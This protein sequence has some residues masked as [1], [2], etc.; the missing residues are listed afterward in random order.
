MVFSWKNKW[1]LDFENPLWFWKI[2]WSF[3]LSF[4]PYS[5]E[6]S[7]RAI[8]VKFVLVNFK[9]HF[10]IFLMIW[11]KRIIIS[12]PRSLLRSTAQSTYSIRK[13]YCKAAY[14]WIYSIFSS[15]RSIFKIHKW[16]LQN[17]RISAMYSMVH[18]SA[19]KCVYLVPFP[20]KNCHFEI[21]NGIFW[22]NLSNFDWFT[23]L[24]CMFVVGN[25][26]HMEKA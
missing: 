14:Y 4:T 21:N 18:K 3:L 5:Q 15:N 16:N 2:H 1:V 13:W 26:I 10:R 25:Q 24:D 9:Q 8:Q 22:P 11:K 19:W 20:R 7:I 23:F 6:E 12:L 17:L